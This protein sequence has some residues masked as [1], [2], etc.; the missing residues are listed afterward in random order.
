[1]VELAARIIIP[2]LM[3]RDD[4][5]VDIYLNSSGPRTI[6]APRNDLRMAIIITDQEPYMAGS[7]V[8]IQPTLNL[9]NIEAASI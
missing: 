4:I 6:E 2:P 7:K 8:A 9:T 3:P 1:V 5:A